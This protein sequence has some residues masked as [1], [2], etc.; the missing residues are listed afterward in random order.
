M[1]CAVPACGSWR[2]CWDAARC[3]R[4]VLTTCCSTTSSGRAR[5]IGKGRYRASS[6]EVQCLS[7][8]D[9]EVLWRWWAR[10]W[11]LQAFVRHTLNG[12]ASN[13]TGSSPSFASHRCSCL[14]FSIHPLFTH[15]L[16]PLPCPCACRHCRWI[17][18]AAALRLAPSQLQRF[19][20]DSRGAATVEPNI[21]QQWM[22]V[23][24]VWRGA[25]CVLT[26]FFSCV[27]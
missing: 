18:E 4:R 13:E 1:S 12:S 5:G 20:R 23:H 7:C 14:L 26:V 8:T 24:A 6:A 17:T 10:R 25:G 21:Q 15:A 22:Q 27:W 3:S 11:R 2:R 16:G 9:C 19:V